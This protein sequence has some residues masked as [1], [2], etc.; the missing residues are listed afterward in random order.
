MIDQNEPFKVSEMTR[1]QLREAKS[2]DFC[3]WLACLG[4]TRGRQM[5]NAWY[6][7]RYPQGIGASY[8]RKDLELEISDPILSHR[9]VT[10]PASTVST[11]YAGALTTVD[12]LATGFIETAIS[13]SLLGRVPGMRKVPFGVKVPT[14]TAGANYAWIGEAGGKPTSSLSF[15]DGA[16]LARLKSAAILVFTLEFIR[17]ISAGTADSLR[18]TIIA[19]LTKFTDTSF[20]DPT[21]AAIAGTRPASITNGL[22][23]V[24][25]TGN[26]QADVQ[27]LLTAFFT[28]RPGA[29]PN[30]ALIA[31]AAHAAQIKSWNSGGGVGLPVLATEAAGGITVAV[32]GDGIVFADDGAEIDISNQAAI[33]MADPATSPP[34]AAT[35]ITSLW[36]MNLVGYRVERFVN[37]F[38]SPTSVAYLAA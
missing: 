10:G 17:A 9:A 21:S 31:N 14:Q 16:T 24:A 27:S 30:T 6:L 38:A 11:A 15:A 29:S 34:T 28:Q 8:V 5:A 26:Y 3:R 32:D 4:E 22:T 13:A 7:Q 2:L 35:I 12:Q 19:G 18:R 36:E 25:S 20:L 37:W 33:E 1:A 23:P